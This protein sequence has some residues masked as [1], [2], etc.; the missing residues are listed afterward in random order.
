M[1]F[2]INEIA[3]QMHV[4]D[5]FGPAAPS[6]DDSGDNQPI[7]REELLRECVER[8]MQQ[9]RQAKAFPGDR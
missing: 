9:L 5:G 1:A 2:E 3:I 6:G 4:Q 8:V 7:D